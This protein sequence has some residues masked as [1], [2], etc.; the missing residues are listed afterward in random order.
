MSDDKVGVCD[1]NVNGE[2]GKESLESGLHLLTK[3]IAAWYQPGALRCP[4]AG[5]VQFTSGGRDG[6]R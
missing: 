4:G 3:G 1:M 5:A 6:K 2:G